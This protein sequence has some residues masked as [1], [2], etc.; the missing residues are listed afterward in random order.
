[1]DNT[2]SMGLSIQRNRY[3]LATEKSLDS[4]VYKDT[5]IYKAAKGI[6]KRERPYIKE[7]GGKKRRLVS[8]CVCNSSRL[9]IITLRVFLHVFIQVFGF[10]PNFLILLCF[11]PSSFLL[12]NKS[13]KVFFPP[14]FMPGR[15]TFVLFF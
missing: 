5:H 10:F 13:S 15:F 7:K 4:S 6:E 8:E 2:R 11:Y 3:L 14:S 1:M 9:I 12:V